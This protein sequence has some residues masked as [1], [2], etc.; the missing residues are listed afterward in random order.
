MVYQRE[1]HPLGE[2]RAARELEVRRHAV[3]VDDHPAC[4]A[5]P[6]VLHVVDEDRGVGEHDALGA[7]WEMSRSCHS[8]TFSSP[9]CA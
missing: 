4:D 3:G 5:E 8:A 7:E 6:E 1:Q 9:V 2:E